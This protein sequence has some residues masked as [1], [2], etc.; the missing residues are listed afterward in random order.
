MREIDLPPELRVGQGYGRVPW[1]VR[2]FWESYVGWFRLQS[3]TELYPVDA[4]DAVADLAELLGPEAVATRAHEHL[5][6][7]EPVRALLLAEAIDDADLARRAHDALLA[8]DGDN[9]WLGGWL[10]DQRGAT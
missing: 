6:A 8:E 5:A 1:A 4:R 2:T 7:G 3:S 9:F 10:R